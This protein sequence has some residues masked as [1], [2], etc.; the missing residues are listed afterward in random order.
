[1]Q[2]R[3]ENVTNNHIDELKDIYNYYVLNTTYTFH[4]EPLSD[5]EMKNN[6]YF[7]DPRNGALTIMLDNKIVGYVTLAKHKI[8]E[9]YKDTGEISIYLHKNFL[10][11]GIGKEALKFIEK[12]AID[13]KYHT[14]IATIALGNIN[15]IK[16]FE[17]SGY[18]KCAH[19]KEVA[20]KFGKY[21]DVC[22]YQKMI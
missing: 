20:K 7:N 6:L 14:L 4:E 9:A 15:S 13:K 3:F 8:R 12:V 5:A 16:L 22:S 10:H 19:F 11:L 2:I 18:K 1:M 17:S 21:L